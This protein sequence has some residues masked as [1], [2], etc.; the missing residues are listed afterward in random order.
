MLET[1]QYYKKVQSLYRALYRS[2]YL[3]IMSDYSSGQESD[4]IHDELIRLRD[5]LMGSNVFE[6]AKGSIS[7]VSND[8]YKWGYWLALR[9]KKKPMSHELYYRAMIQFA[10]M[11]G[12]PF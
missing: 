6:L 10:G 12:L 7:R 8:P 1:K 2:E 4:E 11:D 5:D 9:A 3:D